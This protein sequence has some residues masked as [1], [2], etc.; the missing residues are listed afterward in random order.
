[1]AQLEG[2]KIKQNGDTYGYNGNGN[3]PTHWQKQL[4]KAVGGTLRAPA[5]HESMPAWGW[6]HHAPRHEQ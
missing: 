6:L 4:R 2:K 5:A 1:M 3:G